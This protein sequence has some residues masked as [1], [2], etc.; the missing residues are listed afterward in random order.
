MFRNHPYELPTELVNEILQLLSPEDLAKFSMVIRRVSER[1]MQVINLIWHKKLKQHFPYDFPRDG[2][3]ESANAKAKFINLYYQT[4]RKL[5]LKEKRLFSY[6]KERDIHRLDM[7]RQRWQFIIPDLDLKD[8]G[9]L[10]RVSLIVWAGKLGSQSL[11]NYLYDW[12]RISY[13]LHDNMLD[14]TKT[15]YRG[16]TILHWAVMCCQPTDHILS[17]I[18][19]GVDINHQDNDG[20]TP[21]Y[22]TAQF[23]YL[24]ISKILLAQQN[25]NV[26]QC[27]KIGWTPL[28]QAADCGYLS[29]VQELVKVMISVDVIDR[30]GQT[31][32]WLAAHEGHLDV[33]NELIAKN[34]N[35]NHAKDN[36]W[37]PLHA[38]TNQGHSNVVQSLI[39]NGANIRLGDKDGWGSL[40]LASR[41]GYDEIVRKLIASEARI[42]Q[43]ARYSANTPLHVAAFNGHLRVVQDLV[44]HGAYI[45][46]VNKMG[47]TPLYMAAQSGYL[48]VVA[49]LL[50]HGADVNLVS[51]SGESP[52]EV[53][54]RRGHNAVVHTLNKQQLIHYH[55]RIGALP[56]QYYKTSIPFF[57]VGL[58]YCAADKKAA[59]EALLQVIEDKADKSTLE[60]YRGALNNGELAVIYRRFSI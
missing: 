12:V 40:F 41:Q 44:V 13:I 19:Q 57:G 46:S 43:C 30:Y 38:A 3:V 14:V 37:T 33:V 52:I 54:I 8:S 20:Y 9:S 45:N 21:M 10:E 48:E 60:E 49:F 24:E 59:A 39:D 27:S 1:D 31:P 28:H 18:A 35:V 2:A 32:L 26:V 50:S 34:A 15:D 4:Y 6:V 51:K 58:G 11:L 5:F 17:L 22:V 7:L 36:G 53:A 16:R 42:N 29:I 25:I 55:A 23:G 47:E 56:S